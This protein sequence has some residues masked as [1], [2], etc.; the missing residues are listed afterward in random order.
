MQDYHDTYQGHENSLNKHNDNVRTYIYTYTS[1][2]FCKC[3]KCIF[4]FINL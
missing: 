4:F 1:C 2:I 3:V